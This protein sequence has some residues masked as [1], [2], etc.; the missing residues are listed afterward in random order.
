MPSIFLKIEPALGWNLEPRVTRAAPAQVLLHDAMHRR[1]VAGASSESHGERDLVPVMENA[2]IVA[3][4]HVRRD[5]R[6]SAR[7][8]QS[9]ARQDSNT[10]A[11]NIVRSRSGA[12]SRKCRFCQTAPP[13]VLGIPT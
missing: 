6:S 3:E 2:R 10:S 4:L 8:P 1:R 5:R 9:R 12:G 13:T 11:M 7:P